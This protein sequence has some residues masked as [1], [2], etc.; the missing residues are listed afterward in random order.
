MKKTSE[1]IKFN[2]IDKANKKHNNK[3]DYS[4]VNYVNAKTKVIINCPIHG[5]FQQTPEKHLNC[6]YGCQK[7]WG[8]IKSETLKNAVRPPKKCKPIEYYYNRLTEKY[9]DNI[10]FKIDDWVGVDDTNVFCICKIHGEF[11]TKYNSLMN[12]S[13]KCG[14]PKCGL[15]RKNKSK[16]KDY[17]FVESQL[18]NKHNNF[19]IYPIENADNYINKESK[20]NII[21]PIHGEFVKSAQKHLSGQGCFECLI[22]SLVRD[23]VLMGGYCDN[24]FKNNNELSNKKSFLYYLSINNGK[25]F[26]IGITTKSI[27]D[28]IKGIKSKAKHFNYKLEIDSLLEVKMKLSDA[29]RIEQQILKENSSHRIYSKW[30]TELLRIDVLQNIKNLLASESI[31]L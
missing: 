22:E 6:K 20:I 23:G 12:K 25:M 29:F 30:S 5:E 1:I 7:C 16:T 10:S 3:F 17:S 13:T 19:Y 18:R 24:L 4:L 11:I 28:R 27:K 26:K 15:L 31:I 21:C 2:F 14:C 9:K 8:E